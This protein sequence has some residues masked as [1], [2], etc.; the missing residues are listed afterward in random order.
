V[1]SSIEYQ[2]CA[3]TLI[4]KANQ[5]AHGDKQM[6]NPDM[7]LQ[8]MMTIAIARDPALQILKFEDRWL[9]WSELRVPIDRI[10]Q[11]IKDSG[12]DERSAVTFVPRNY[13]SAIATLL[14]LIAQGRTIRMIYAFQSPEGIAREIDRHRSAIVIAAAKDFTD[15]VKAVLT[16]HGMAAIALTDMSADFVPGFETA[17][18][19]R[20]IPASSEP[21]IQIHTSGT[22]GLPKPFAITQAM[23]AR[24]HVGSRL[25]TASRETVYKEPPFML[26]F[27]IGNISGIYSTVPTIIRGQRAHLMERFSLD[28]WRAYI[29]EHQP[30]MG[31]GPPTV[32]QMILDAEIPKEELASLKY[33]STGAAPLDP[34]VQR[35]FED[36]YGIAVLLSYGA[37][38]FAGPVCG[39]TPELH[40]Q[41]GQKKFGSVGRTFPGAKIRV[42]DPDTGEEKSAGEEGILEV[43]SQRLEPTWIRTAD[44]GVMDADGFLFIRGRADGAITRGGFKLIPEVIERA[45]LTHPAV[46]VATVVGIP[47]RRLGQIPVAAIQLTPEVATPSVEELEA[48]LRKQVLATHIP[49]QWKFINETPK[50]PS[51]KIDRPGVAR[52]FT[53]S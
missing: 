44:I 39:M 1:W 37:T 36:R 33:F 47:D 34:T 40:A 6:I 17:H 3:L 14:G 24:H 26:F 45:L 35:A 12:A 46:S 53:G 7:T 51:M 18:P 2:G 25:G 10:K 30:V 43:V 38:E 28:A 29:K 15:E 48:H 41:W 32:V 23:I 16:A 52:L 27:P 31:G 50:N 9:T 19:E 42:I 8:E 21:L 4:N 49:V 20:A 5:L 22:T 13:P 11:L